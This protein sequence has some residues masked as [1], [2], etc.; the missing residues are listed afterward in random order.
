M[1]IEKKLIYMLQWSRRS[2]QICPV[3]GRKLG[4][5]EGGTKGGGGGLVAGRGGVGGLAS[6]LLKN[7]A[8][9]MWNGCAC[10]VASV[11]TRR[12]GVTKLCVTVGCE[13][14]LNAY[15]WPHA[16]PWLVAVYFCHSCFTLVLKIVSTASP[17][18]SSS[19]STTSFFFFF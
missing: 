1:A 15:S 2:W 14:I 6:S 17:P 18:P 11:A 16:L 9:W 4:W 10:S 3:L 5:G 12:W 19:S 13:P 7:Q 8:L